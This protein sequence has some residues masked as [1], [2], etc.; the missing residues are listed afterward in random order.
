LIAMPSAAVHHFPRKHSQAGEHEL[1]VPFALDHRQPYTPY[2]VFCSAFPCP[3]VS[4]YQLSPT[5]PT[6]LSPSPP[7][8]DL[9]RISAYRRRSP[10][11]LSAIR[12]PSPKILSILSLKGLPRTDREV[13]LLNAT[14]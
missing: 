7:D 12:A 2:P 10:V 13:D 4:K 3:I 5:A 1:E 6:T 9:Q 14:P 11:S 8:Y